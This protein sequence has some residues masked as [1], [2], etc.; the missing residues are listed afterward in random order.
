MDK[1]PPTITGQ[2]IRI[3]I[4]DCWLSVKVERIE[5]ALTA[6]DDFHPLSVEST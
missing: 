3:R 6:K 1:R 2:V 4:T 5:V